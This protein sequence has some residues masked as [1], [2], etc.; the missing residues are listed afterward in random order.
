MPTYKN[1]TLAKTTGRFSKFDDKMYTKKRWKELS[2][3]HKKINPVC[4]VCAKLDITKTTDVSDHHLPVRLWSGKTHDMSNL[5]PM[6]HSH[7]NQ[8]S[9]IERNIFNR[10]QW[11]QVFADHELFSDND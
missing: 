11:M 8:K 3:L 4:Y 9:A 5:K 10:A 7:H 2:K 1:I 6:C